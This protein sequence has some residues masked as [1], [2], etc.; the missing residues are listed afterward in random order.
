MTYPNLDRLLAPRSVAIVGANERGNIGAS[1][2]KNAVDSGF[3]GAISAINP[4]YRTLQGRPC[5]P[6]L[7]D[8]GEAPDTVICSV[9]AAPAMKVVEEAAA[10]GV[11][12][13]ILLCNG[14]ADTETA[15]G[16][17]RQDDLER[18]ARAHEMAVAGP[19]CMGLFSRR[20]RFDSSF[21]QKPGPVV[22]GNISI[23]SQSGGLTNGLLELAQNRALGFN[24]VI[25]AG[26]EAVVD[27]ADYIEWLADEP[28]TRAIISVMEGVKNGPRLRLALEYAT[29]QKPVVVLKLGRS[30]AGQRATMAHT[31]ALAASDEVFAALCAQSGAIL[32]HTIDL[33]LETAALLA[34]TPLP[35]GRRTMLFS[36]SGG[37]SVLTT[38]L[39]V[40]AGVELAPV[41]AETN[42]KLQEFL[43]TSR[44]FINPIDVGAAVPLHAGPDTIENITRIL[45]SDPAVD[46]VGGVM[47]VGRNPSQRRQQIFAQVKAG[48]AGSDKP[49]IVLPEMTVHWDAP[50]ADLGVHVGA[51]L[52]DGL[53][54]LRAMGDYAEYRRREAPPRGN[55]A[56]RVAAPRRVDRNVLTEFET[57]SLLAA[58][59]FP[60]TREELVGSPAEAAAAAG[61]I[62]YPVALK[63]QSPDLM[64]K[65]DAG[66]VVLGIPDDARLA[67]AYAAILKNASIH[68]P[69][70]RIDG[71]LVQEMISG[72]VEM[73]LGM[74]RDPTFGPVI[75]LSPGGVFVELLGKAAALRVVPFGPLDA[76]H[77]VSE[78]AGAKLLAGFRGRP[79]ADRTALIELATKFA[80]WIEALDDTVAAVDLNPVMVLPAGRGVKIAD[81][82][83][84]FSES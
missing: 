51:S 19:N 25:S 68:A 20:R 76:E 11:K 39:A 74:H 56:G 82:T 2:L 41:S 35:R 27:T 10:C 78:A 47:V 9:P 36:S 8:I 52:E 65:T 63:L 46:V 28:E 60:V 3:S 58:A 45:I 12:S 55:P 43:K 48:A 79:P 1:A 84:E 5:Y 13:M 21:F 7:R 18:I 80:V 14:F 38:D 83:L 64:H 77:L 31:G 70:A 71:M 33:A 44:S 54:A 4:N 23:V 59:G 72:G 49:V 67:E 73:L 62:G 34:S 22:P 16:R 15:E 17:Q 30:E 50:P 40:K 81:A 24:Y 26:N 37:A 32:V 57:K 69:N 6:S 42:R 53:W 61:R 66:G 29:R 75:V